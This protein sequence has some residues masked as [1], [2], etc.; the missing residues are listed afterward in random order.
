[1][2]DKKNTEE[3]FDFIKKSASMFHSVA[4]A[5]KYLEDAGYTY[6]REKDKWD[7]KKGGKYY[8]IRNN[9]SLIAF[10]IAKDLK[11]YHFQMT[12]AHSDSPTYKV[13]AVAELEGPGQYLRL[14]TEAYGGMIDSSWLDKPLSLAGRVLVK[15][16]G[17]LVSQ[18][19]NIDKDI[20][21]I[22]SLAI[23]L[24]RDVNT[25]YAYNKQVDLMPLFSAGEME[26]G[27]YDKMLA[28][29]LGLEVEDIVAKDLF[30]VNRQEAKIWGYKDE[31]AS[32]PKLDDLQC[33][34]ASLKAFL[35]ADNNS[36]I[37]V[38][39]LF[40]NEEVGSN[41][42]QGA[43]STLLKDSLLRINSGLGFEEEDYHVAVAKSFLVSCD[44]AHALH[45]NHPEMYDQTNRTMINKGIVI[46]EA[47]NQK[48][49]TDAFSRAVFLE[50]C[51]MA[52]VP[53]Q[54][55]AN[56]SDKVGGSTLGNLSNTQVSV[57]AVDIGIAQVGMHSSY[58][59]CGIKDTTYMIEA[60]TKFF[61]TNI[62]IDG[63]DSVEFK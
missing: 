61:D 9:S 52:D 29:E 28:Q 35:E 42:K 62:L 22:P 54:F 16:N 58:E 37:N 5:A 24:N 23:H 40:D 44:N 41:T 26:K 33:A 6:L 4:T 18:L 47:A 31:F 45:P 10:N 13:K 25:G 34:F 11:D 63:A 46:K 60:L 51:K 30:L 49:T 27:D 15:R 43:M 38:Y 32:S 8:T 12:A 7:I 39:C 56:R 36:H 48:Y 1:M 3:L 17:K 50:I 55:F 2:K 59:T 20:L 14:N 19:L 57:H 21:M 53:S